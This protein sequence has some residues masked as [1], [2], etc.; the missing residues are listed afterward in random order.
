MKPAR[1]S[2]K[3]TKKPDWQ[4]KLALD[5]IKILFARADKMFKTRPEYSHRYVKMARKIAM[6]YNVRIPKEMKNR[7]CRKCSSYLVSGKTGRTR[8]R[9]SQKSLIRYCKE[10]GSISRHPYRKEKDKKR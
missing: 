6:R 9:S 7:F 1:K 10:C 5:R 8:T 3:P 2:R 4:K